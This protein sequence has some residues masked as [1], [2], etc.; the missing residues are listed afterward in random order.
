MIEPLDVLAVMAHPD[1][2]EIFCGGA[3]I[4]S[5]ESGE[6]TGVLDLTAGEAGTRG[7]VRSRAREAAAAA[8]VMGLADRRCAGLQDAALVND[9]QSRVVVARL[10]RILRPR[11]I[12]THWTRGRHPDHR[13]AA[14]LTR[15]AAFLAGLRK[16]PAEGAPHRPEKVVYALAFREDPVK[17][18]FVVD[19]TAQMDRKIEAL[20][21]YRSQFQ[22]KSG[23]GEVF[24]GGDRPLFDQ[25]RSVHATYGSLIRRRYG[26][27]YW[28][29][30]TTEAETLGTVP[31]T[32]F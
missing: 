18:T 30:E 32:T 7:T 14:R 19:I 3:L 15:D 13:A 25:I 8:D 26:E 4:K 16:L 20:A 22:G 11:V 1:D 21:A 24:P 5:A 27:P 9:V 31:V 23:M 17:P 2:A 6:R 12:V 28:T 29:E 10:M